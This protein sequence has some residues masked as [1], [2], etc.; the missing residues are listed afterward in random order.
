MNGIS[1]FRLFLPGQTFQLQ[2]RVGIANQRKFNEINGCIFTPLIRVELSSVMTTPEV[3][4]SE[5]SVTKRSLQPH[6]VK[7]NIK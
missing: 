2:L 4:G 1:V 5:G 6:E 7:L 3:G